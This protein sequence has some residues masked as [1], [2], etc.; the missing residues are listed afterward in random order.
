MKKIE[1]R[2]VLCLVLAGLLLAGLALFL[3]RF[4]SDGGHWAS[5]PFNRHLYNSAG[6]LISGTLLDRD[7]EVLSAVDQSGS[8]T[9]PDGETRRKSILHVVGDPYGSIGTG[10]LTAFADR[11]TGFDLLN[12]AFG[13]QRGN[14]VYLTIDA[15]LNETAYRALN[16]RKGTV[17]VYNYQTGE[18]LCLVSS[19]SFDPRNIPSGLETDPSY[20]GVYLNRFLSS[21]FPPGSIFKTVTLAAALE[22]L[23]DLEERTWVCEGSA[24]IGDGTVTC[25]AAH[26][27]QDIREALANSCNVVFGQLAVELGG[28]TLERYAGKAGL[29]SRY[30]VN[31]IP[32]A[33][34]SFSLT[35]ISDNDLAWAG[36][37]QYHDAVNPCSMLVYMGAIANGGRAAVPC[38][39]LQVDTPGLPRPRSAGARPRTPGSP[40]SSGMRTTPTPFS[41]WWRT[42]G[43][44]PPRPEM[45]PPG[46]STLWCPPDLPRPA[47]TLPCRADFLPPS[48]CICYADMVQLT[49][50]T[51]AV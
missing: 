42:A 39:L 45:W 40:A 15:D 4:F 36:V 23:P 20:D 19:P 14:Q 41:C 2:A 10:A 29:T 5:S 34:G 12:G 18:I 30:S 48:R 51:A 27:E 47:E 26:G 35:G 6:Q 43:A 31:G 25:T 16:G 9:Y 46:C 8:R 28:S 49:Y 7:G 44:A 24:Q 1:R 13:A 3:F 50:V 11:L 17:A 37:G 32:T 38:L 33:A 22:E 21:T